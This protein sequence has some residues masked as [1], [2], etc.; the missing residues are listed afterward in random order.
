[1]SVSFECR[2]LY[3]RGTCVWLITRPE[4]S[5]RVLCVWVWFW[6]LDNEEALTHWGLWSYGKKKNLK[7]LRWCGDQDT[8]EKTEDMCF[9][10]PT[11]VKGLCLYQRRSGAQPTLVYTDFAGFYPGGTTS[12]AWRA[13]LPLRLVPS[14][15]PRHPY[16]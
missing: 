11:I 8:C 2:V 9:G 14:K 7:I 12:K 10:V 16:S 15:M 6:S 13:P 4:K 5:Y 1:M 3:G